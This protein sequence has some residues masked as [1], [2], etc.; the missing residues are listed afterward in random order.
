LNFLLWRRYDN[1]FPPFLS[2]H[3][4]IVAL[5]QV[6]HQRRLRCKRSRSTKRNSTSGLVR[7]T[8]LWGISNV[9]GKLLENGILKGLIK[10]LIRTKS[11][12]NLPKRSS[13]TRSYPCL[14]TRKTTDPF[15][16]SASDVFTS[17]PNRNPR[18]VG[19]ARAASSQNT[20]K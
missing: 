11:E 12:K 9:G 10:F 6:R 16:H 8:P 1:F 18:P 14:N 4:D 2:S 19:N 15:A 20:G 7:K 5:S 3:S 17:W 13:P